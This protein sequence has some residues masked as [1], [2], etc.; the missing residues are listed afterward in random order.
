MRFDDRA[1]TMETRAT[2]SILRGKKA[3]P[4]SSKSSS[5]SSSSSLNHLLLCG[6]L[7]P[8]LLFATTTAPRPV[9]GGEQH[10]TRKNRSNDA[11]FYGR[12]TRSSGEEDVARFVGFSSSPEKLFVGAQSFLAK[13]QH[14]LEAPKLRGMASFVPRKME[15][16]NETEEEPKESFGFM[17]DAFIAGQFV[18][19]ASPDL[20][21]GV[22]VRVPRAA[23]AEK[24]ELEKMAEN[25]E[26]FVF[27]DENPGEKVEHESETSVVFARIRRPK[28]GQFE[29]P[30][31]FRARYAKPVF[32]S[33]EEAKREVN[34]RE[35]KKN[36]SESDANTDRE[37]DTGGKGEEK[38]EKD[39]TKLGKTHSRIVFPNV[40][41]L[42]RREHDTGAWTR[43]GELEMKGSWYVPIAYSN[44]AA[45]VK[46]VSILITLGA[47]AFVFKAM[48]QKIT[49][50]EKYG[51][52]KRSAA[53]PSLKKRR[54]KKRN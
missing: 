41:I 14:K 46:M 12:R 7:L 51:G 9:V 24:H 19:G 23:F 15:G 29:L 21:V 10:R 17:R 52:S 44:H 25:V 38:E 1:K 16:K 54:S 8:C 13:L 2:S 36:K 30:M 11:F 31:K 43:V 3:L 18:S 27:G 53:I 47:G 39:E 49:E 26:W 28:R 48:R 20:D 22:A 42:A 40:V 33:G 6:L 50:E 45:G 37:A 35:A 4:S 5:S 34:V 32:Q